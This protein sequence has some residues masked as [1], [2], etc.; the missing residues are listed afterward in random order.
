MTLRDR[1]AVVTG[2]GRGIGEA[3]AIA[4]VNAGAAVAVWDLDRERAE[5]AAKRLVVERGG[6]AVAVG[7]DV[8][9]RASVDAAVAVT[10]E[11]L[12]PIDILVNNA[13]ID[14]IGPFL[15]SDPSSWDLII[16][17]NLRGPIITCYRIVRDM[18]EHRTGPLGERRP[19]H[20]LRA[21]SHQVDRLPSRCRRLRHDREH[22]RSASVSTER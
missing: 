13:G 3:I 19:D 11:E 14:V 4:L 15:D 21:A 2:G 7:V 5:G 9:D 18:V 1:V 16:D 17:V 10:G 12:G 20:V 6:R 22:R 8:A